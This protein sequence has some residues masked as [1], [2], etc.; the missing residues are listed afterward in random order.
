MADPRPQTYDNHA[1]LVPL[2]H[3]VAIPILLANVVWTLIRVVTDVSVDTVMAALVAIALVMIGLFARTF[4]LR[5]QDRIIRVEERLRMQRLLPDD[6]QTRIDEFAIDQLV[7]LR[8]ASDGELGDLARRVL[9]EDIADRRAIKQLV[10]VW[11]ADH[12]RV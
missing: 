9:D 2:Y 7:A 11:R 10:A 6:L 8:F 1:R 3:Y 5:A 12:H 4:A